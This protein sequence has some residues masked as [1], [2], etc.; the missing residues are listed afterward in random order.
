MFLCITAT[1][2]VQRPTATIMPSVLQS[3]ELLLCVVVTTMFQWIHSMAFFTIH[4]NR[5]VSLFLWNNMATENSQ[6]MQTRSVY[7]SNSSIINVFKKAVERICQ[8]M[9]MTWA[10]K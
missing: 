3:M 10:A 2:D 4:K 8:N 7:S 9:L 1:S 5:L 6:D